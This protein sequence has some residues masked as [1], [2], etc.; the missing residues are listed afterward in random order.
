MLSR[1]LALGLSLSLLTLAV[2]CTASG[3]DELQLWMQEERNA[4]RPQ[5]TPIPEPGRF[6]PQVY[7]SERMTEPFSAEKMASVTGSVAATVIN[8]KL[9]EPELNRRKQPLEA[10]PLDT[11][12]MVGSLNRDG[13]LVALVKVDSLLYQVRSGSYLGQNYGRVNQITETEITLREIVQDPSGEWTE[14]PAALQL[15]EDASK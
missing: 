12:R 1:P 8:S 3:E 2:G 5:V 9:L 10:F 7:L 13:Q 6:E 11:M 15:Q 4:I 14:R